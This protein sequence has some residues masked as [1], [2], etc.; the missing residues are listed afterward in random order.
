MGTGLKAKYDEIWVLGGYLLGTGIA[1]L[2]THPGPHYPGYTPPYLPTREW[3][4]LPAAEYK[5]AVGLKSVGQ[6][7]LGA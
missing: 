6:L 2:P 3:L 4:G 5:V 7:T 1:P